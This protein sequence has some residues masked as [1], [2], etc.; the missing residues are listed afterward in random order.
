MVFTEANVTPKLVLPEPKPKAK[1]ESRGRIGLFVG[2]GLVVAAAAVA[3]GLTV[4]H[5]TLS[6]RSTW[7]ET[8]RTQKSCHMNKMFHL[9]LFNLSCSEDG[10]AS[11]VSLVLWPLLCK[12]KL[13]TFCNTKEITVIKVTV[14]AKSID[15]QYS[16]SSAEVTMLLSSLSN[17]LDLWLLCSII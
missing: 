1:P 4:C 14:D 11:L 8:S 9:P 6:S 16:M 10:T 2:L 5:W 3:A 7:S 12:L 13:K 17:Y 15:D